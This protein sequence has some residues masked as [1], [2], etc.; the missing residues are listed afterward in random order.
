MR[1]QILHYNNDK[2]RLSPE[3]WY[4]G[5]L[6]GGSK[7]QEVKI[8]EFTLFYDWPQRKGVKCPNNV[9]KTSSKT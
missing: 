4:E 2:N 3:Y 7:S 6:C 9:S 5:S 1:T 8:I